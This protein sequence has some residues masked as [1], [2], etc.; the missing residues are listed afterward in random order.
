[1]KTRRKFIQGLL[2]SATFVFFTNLSWRKIEEWQLIHIPKYN[3]YLPPINERWVATTCLQCPSVC[4][5]LVRVI[6]NRAV[7]IEG[8]PLSPNNR[9]G[10]CPKGQAGLQ[11]LYDPDRITGPMKRIGERGRGKFERVDWS[12]AIKELTNRLKDLRV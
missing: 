10:V 1:M 6:D 8:N 2:A 9:G 5:L 4:Q 7:K 3:L 12:D 11:V